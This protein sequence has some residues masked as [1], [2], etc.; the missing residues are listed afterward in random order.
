MNKFNLLAFTVLVSAFATAQS[1]KKGA[2]LLSVSEGST[3]ANYSTRNLSNSNF[4]SMYKAEVDGIRDPLIIEYGLNNKWG[5]GLSS[6][7][8][9]FKVSP[10]RYYGFRLPHTNPI[11]V[12]TSELTFDVNYHFF[13]TKKLD[14]SAFASPGLF[15]LAFKGQYSDLAYQYEAKGLI[16]RVGS[17]ARY[18]FYKRL[19]LFGMA[20]LY[21]GTASPTSNKSN[22]VGQSIATTVS[23]RALEFGLCFRFF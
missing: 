12:K 16:L 4:S 8:D 5:I 14:V 1:F 17:K 6:G 2:L 18:Y 15:S 22:T 10:N 7:A 23:G 11:E 21:S 13:V 20:S 19:G 3:T 9:I